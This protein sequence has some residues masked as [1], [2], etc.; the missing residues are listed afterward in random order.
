MAYHV[1][2]KRQG[3]IGTPWTEVSTSVDNSIQVTSYDAIFGG[4]LP[5]SESGIYQGGSSVFS[6]ENNYGFNF[7]VNKAVY[8]SSSP[9]AGTIDDYQITFDVALLKLSTTSAYTGRYEVVQILDTYTIPGT[10]PSA[11]AAD[12]KASFSLTFH[13]NSSD[14]TRLGLIIR[15]TAKDFNNATIQAARKLTITSRKL[16]IIKNL[17]SDVSSNQIVRKIGVHADPGFLMCINNEPIRVGSSG[18]YELDT[19]YRIKFFGVATTNQF[20]LDYAYE[21]S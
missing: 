21:D 9:N 7:T 6:T 13:P 4:A 17:L 20:V 3:N 1:G 5:F 8:N 11:A 19:N 18:S 15:R 2:Q 12:K 10:T 16:F 14:C